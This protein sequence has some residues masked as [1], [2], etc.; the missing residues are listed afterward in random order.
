MILQL[1][2]DGFFYQFSHCVEQDNRG[3]RPKRVIGSFVWFRNNNEQQ[4]F[5]I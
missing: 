1:F 3:K 4:H 2:A 5:E